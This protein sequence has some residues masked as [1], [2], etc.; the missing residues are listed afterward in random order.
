MSWKVDFSPRALKF[1]YQNNMNEDVILEKVSL[2]L[3]KFQGEDVNIDIK[4][5]KGEWLGFYRIRSAK[6]RIIVEVQFDLQRAYIEAI[7][8]RG[9]IYK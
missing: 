4:K 6:L 5:L 8:W 3:K 9:N 1:L 7:D 2:A